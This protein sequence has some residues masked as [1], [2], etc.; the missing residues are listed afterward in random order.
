MAEDNR[1]VR[2]VFET[3]RGSDKN[4]LYAAI[5]LLQALNDEQLEVAAFLFGKAV[6]DEARKR[7]RRYR[8]G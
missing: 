8:A 2:D 3:F 7:I 1:T 6:E 4:V 5:G